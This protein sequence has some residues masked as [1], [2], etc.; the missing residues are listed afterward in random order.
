MTRILDKFIKL[1]KYS[2]AG[3]CV[4]ELPREQEKGGGTP[5]LW[6]HSIRFLKKITK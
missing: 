5:P 6:R 3:S 2:F 4:E 1:S